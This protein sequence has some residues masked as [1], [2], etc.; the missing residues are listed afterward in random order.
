[1]KAS[2]PMLERA[3]RPVRQTAENS[4]G[5]FRDLIRSDG[6][7]DCASVMGTLLHQIAAAS[8]NPEGREGEVG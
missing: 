8:G 6:P 7:P 5:A 2:A 3:V 1:M 4:R